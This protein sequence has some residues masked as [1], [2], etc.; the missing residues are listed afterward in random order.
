MR[1]LSD[2]TDEQLKAGLI[3]AARTCTKFPTPADIRNCA[4]EGQGSRLELEAE[5]ALNEIDRLIDR[6]GCEWIPQGQ[7]PT[8]IA[9]LALRAIGG[10]VAYACRDE[11]SAPF[12]RKDFVDAY[13]RYSQTEPLDS[14]GKALKGEFADAIRGIAQTK[15]LA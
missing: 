9:G 10:V 11:K 15:R 5:N 3:G 7:H 4:T 8:G 14:N 12:M 13:K 1:I 2:L 6:H